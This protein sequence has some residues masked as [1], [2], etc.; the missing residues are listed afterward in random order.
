MSSNKLQKIVETH[1]AQTPIVVLKESKFHKPK[2][3]TKNKKIINKKTVD[4]A[5]I[6]K[7][8]KSPKIKEEVVLPS[9]FKAEKCNLSY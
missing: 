8:Q 5:G 6:A 7:V 3:N 9:D 4:P 1:E 2:L